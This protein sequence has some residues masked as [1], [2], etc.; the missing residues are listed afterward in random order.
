MAYTMFQNSIQKRI[1]SF[2]RVG[3]VFMDTPVCYLDK[4]ANKPLVC[5]NF[6]NRFKDGINLLTK[7]MH[8]ET[9]CTSDIE[10]KSECGGIISIQFSDMYFRC[11]FEGHIQQ[12]LPYPIPI[13]L[14]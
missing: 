12:I 10:T 9:D 14:N 5:V 4:I 2:R 6:Q 13:D 1:D 7:F 3:L 11:S 8:S